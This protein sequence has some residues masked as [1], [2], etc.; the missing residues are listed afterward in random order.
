MCAEHVLG[1][2]PVWLDE[3]RLSCYCQPVVEPTHKTSWQKCF[4][5]YWLKNNYLSYSRTWTQ[6]N[7][8]ISKIIY[9]LHTFTIVI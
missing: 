2:R 1:A 6:Y 8:N 3:N 7:Y 9:I 4:I 5:L